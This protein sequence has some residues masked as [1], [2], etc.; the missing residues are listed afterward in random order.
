MTSTKQRNLAMETWALIRT[1]FWRV[2][3]EASLIMAITP[4]LWYLLAYNSRLSRDEL[5]NLIFPVERALPFAVTALVST[6]YLGRRPT[7]SWG[8]VGLVI[9][10]S[11]LGEAVFRGFVWGTQFLLPL[12]RA[13]ANAC[14]PL[15]SL[16]AAFVPILVV[17][18]GE[19]HIRVL[20]DSLRR[21]VKY[22]RLL[23]VHR[24][25][26]IWGALI[27]GLSV[28]AMLKSMIAPSGPLPY[29]PQIAVAAGIIGKA[30]VNVYAL[31]QVGILEL[32]ARGLLPSEGP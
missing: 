5:T 11:I 23:F 2:W 7:F 24:V 29:E 19:T 28:F 9:A 10:L 6:R 20:T 18:F 15:W 16:P 13:V 30:L 21:T 32:E 8:M 22:F 17:S 12:Q 25:L 14:I 27:L 26:V 3:L 4:A 1:K 31:T